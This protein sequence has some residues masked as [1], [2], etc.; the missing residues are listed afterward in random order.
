M[1][2]RR[3]SK[4]ETRLK[5]RT[6]PFRAWKV[7]FLELRVRMSINDKVGV[8]C[9]STSYVLK[10]CP[11]GRITGPGTIPSDASGPPPAEVISRGIHAFLRRK[12]AQAAL[13]RIEFADEACG[14]PKLARLIPVTI[15]PADVLGAGDTVMQG[16]KDEVCPEL[17]GPVV[18]AT[19]VRLS[20]R[21]WT[22][23]T[24]PRGIE[25]RA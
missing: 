23:A 20:R 15:D 18:V 8:P 16:T 24:T 7:R 9:L 22:L 19:R 5:R 6:K 4:L 13:E 25:Q 10:S 21:A 1:C 2:C 17:A 14:L 11:G 12:D 3:D